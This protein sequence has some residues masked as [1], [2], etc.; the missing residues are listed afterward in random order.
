MKDN[1]F[2]KLTQLNHNS[3]PKGYGGWVDRCHGF[4]HS[5]GWEC[6]PGKEV[7]WNLLTLFTTS[8]MLFLEVS[9]VAFLFQGNYASGAQALTRTFLITGFVIALDLLLKA[10]YLFGFGVPLFIDNNENVHKFK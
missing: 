1:Q 5:T 10:L 7:A 3:T 9:L 6:T 2:H 8:G 4:L